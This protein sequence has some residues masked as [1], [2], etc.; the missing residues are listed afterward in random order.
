MASN[1]LA[2]I[3]KAS[4]EMKGRKPGGVGK[5]GRERAAAKN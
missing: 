4:G 2:A 3:K 1:Q 5:R